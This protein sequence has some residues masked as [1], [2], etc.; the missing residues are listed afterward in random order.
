M[1]RPTSIASLLTL[2]LSVAAGCAPAARA[3]EAASSKAPPVTED[4]LKAIRWARIVL[5]SGLVPTEMRG[6]FAAVVP[7]MNKA[8]DRVIISAQDLHSKEGVTVAAIA[9]LVGPADTVR[10]AG[11][12]MAGNVYTANDVET[13]DCRQH[14]YGWMVLFA[15]PA[16]GKIRAA[17]VTIDRWESGL[18]RSAERAIR[19]ACFTSDPAEAKRSRELVDWLSE[20]GGLG[21]SKRLTRWSGQH[22]RGLPVF[23]GRLR[24][25]IG[26]A[27]VKEKWGKPQAEGKADRV[28]TYEFYW[29]AS[30]AESPR[31]DTLLRYGQIG[32]LVSDGKVVKAVLYT[33]RQPKPDGEPKEKAPAKR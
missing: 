4:P 7:G 31:G 14:E 23:Y 21:L 22:D 32:L 9:E 1:S 5:D 16:T 28:E 2:A 27:T 12:K 10:P 26:V 29:D 18:R 3:A 20:Q 6:G 30:P 11:A 25:P 19:E 24:K 13:D 17:A 8:K 33:R 15:E